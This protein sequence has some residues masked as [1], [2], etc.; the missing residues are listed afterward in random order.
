MFQRC[1]E[2]TMSV[3]PTENLLKVEEKPKSQKQHMTNELDVS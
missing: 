1:R 2:N 3:I